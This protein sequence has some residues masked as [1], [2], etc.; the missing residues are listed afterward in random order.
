MDR[1]ATD[2]GLMDPKDAEFMRVKLIRRWQ[3]FGT[4]L[5]STGPLQRQARLGVL[6]TPCTLAAYRYRSVLVNVSGVS[7]HASR[8]Q[9]AYPHAKLVGAIGHVTYNPQYINTVG[10]HYR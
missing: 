7:P 8:W 1:D 10:T 5:P 4:R 6:F 3:S 9:L 2:F